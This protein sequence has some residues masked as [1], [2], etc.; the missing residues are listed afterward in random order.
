MICHPNP[1][2]RITAAMVDNAAVRTFARTAPFIVVGVGAVLW[3]VR[4][5]LWGSLYILGVAVATFF[6]WLPILQQGLID[7]E[8]SL[9]ENGHA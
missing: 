6:S 4:G 2:L 3:S 1:K 7:S 9:R 5:W 8:K